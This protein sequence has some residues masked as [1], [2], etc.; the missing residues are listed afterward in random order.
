VKTVIFTDVGRNKKSWTA[1]TKEV[2]YMWLCEQVTQ[3]A[4][5]MSS[6]V[7]FTHCHGNGKIYTGHN[8]VGNFKIINENEGSGENG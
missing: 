2:G 8:V 3:N 7:A 4:A 1:Q 5:L 6:D